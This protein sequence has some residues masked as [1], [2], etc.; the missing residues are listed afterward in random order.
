M[1]RYTNM[2][3]CKF[4]VFIKIYYPIL[5]PKDIFDQEEYCE[6]CVHYLLTDVIHVHRDHLDV[7]GGTTYVRAGTTWVPKPT[8][9]SD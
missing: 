3:F 9:S 4:F 5:Y 7:L 2:D 6:V 8:A 1:C